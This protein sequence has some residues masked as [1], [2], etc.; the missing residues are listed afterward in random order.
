MNNKNKTYKS[1]VQFIKYA[2]VGAINTIIDI[3]ILNILSFSTGITHGKMLF[4][5]NIIAF[6]IYSICGYNLNKKFTF[7]EGS[8]TSTYFEY[9]S[10]LLFGMILNSCMLVILTSRNPLIHLFKGGS[11]IMKLNHLW[12][13]ICILMDSITIGFFGFLINKFFVFNENKTR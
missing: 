13:N 7:K 4:I 11:N 8:R 1:L 2:F 10:V 5:F 12:F 9:A 3:V 6:S